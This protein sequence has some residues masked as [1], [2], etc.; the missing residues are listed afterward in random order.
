MKKTYSIT[1][2]EDI[3]KKSQEINENSGRKLSAVIELLLDKWNK[4]HEEES[5]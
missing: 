5:E 4:E 1:V 3:V 2:E